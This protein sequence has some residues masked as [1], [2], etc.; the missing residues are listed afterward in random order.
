MIS[1]VT[2]TNRVTQ[3]LAIISFHAEVFSLL[4]HRNAK[5]P[6]E[7]ELTTVDPAMRNIG[8]IFN[9]VCGDEEIDSVLLVRR[10]LSMICDGDPCLSFGMK[11]VLFEIR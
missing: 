2:D 10:A 1:E 4:N 11:A 5:N 9:G 6:R 3:P 8:V 7:T